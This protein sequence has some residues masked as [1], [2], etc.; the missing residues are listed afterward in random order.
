M[1]EREC[2]EGWGGGIVAV[3]VGAGNGVGMERDM[4]RRGREV[5]GW[6][7]W[8]WGMREFAG[9]KSCQ[10]LRDQCGGRGWGVDWGDD[11]D[12]FVGRFRW[13]WRVTF[14]VGGELEEPFAE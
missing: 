13:S 14:G 4:E 5:V 11:G 10:W 2:M 12:D 8:E 1:G 6:T 9:C 3:G 7:F